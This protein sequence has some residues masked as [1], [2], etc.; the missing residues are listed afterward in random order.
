MKKLIISNSIK[1]IAFSAFGLFG[2]S[3]E[4]INQEMV[5]WAEDGNLE[6]VKRYMDK[7]ADVNYVDE[8]NRN[9]GVYALWNAD[10]DGGEMYRYFRSKG[11]ITEHIY[12]KEGNYLHIAAKYDGYFL[13]KEIIMS[14]VDINAKNED[15]QTA[16]LIASTYDELEPVRILLEL[17]ADPTLSDDRD[18]SFFE[19]MNL[20][21][22]ERWNIVL[23]AKLS[24]SQKNRLLE[25]AVTDLENIQ[26]AKEAIEKGAD[27]NIEIY[28]MSLL[29]YYTESLEEVDAEN[30]QPI[31]DMI[32]FLESK[33]AKKN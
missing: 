8:H 15:G 6:E 26:Y 3:Q 21:D 30:R 22:S 11:L 23:N 25:L 19:S 33:G 31:K 9:A 20:E 10:E 32:T 1:T 14:G 29:D 4:N 2:F 27:V 12:P 16:L 24:Q 28:D 18:K 17:G 7:G 5:E 13:F